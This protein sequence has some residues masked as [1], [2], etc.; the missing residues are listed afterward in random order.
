MTFYEEMAELAV[1][2]IAEFGAGVPFL[3]ENNTVDFITGASTSSPEM[4]TL[5]GVL[6]END[7]SLVTGSRVEAGNKLILIDGKVQPEM[8]WK[9]RLDSSIPVVSGVAFA[10]DV[11]WAPNVSFAGEGGVSTVAWTIERIS[12]LKP[13]SIVLLYEIELRQGV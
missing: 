4:V 9:V 6:I 11:P 12:P 3:N 2:L 5:Q 1:E 7:K 13:A 8:S 10:P